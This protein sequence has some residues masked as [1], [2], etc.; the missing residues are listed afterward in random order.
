MKKLNIM[1]I[2]GAMLCAYISAQAQNLPLL[3]VRA[4]ILAFDG[5]EMQVRTREGSNLKIRLSDQTK[6]NVLK[7]IH[8]ADIKQGSFVGITAISHGPGTPLQAREVHLFPEAQRGT[9]EGHY[10][11]DLEPG[12]SMTNANVD[13]IVDTNNGKEMT[14]SYKGGNQKIVVSRD[15]PIVAFAPADAS[16]LKPGTYVFCITQQQADG[17][18]VAQRISVGLNG[19][20]PP[21]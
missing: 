18:L 2:V 12:S 10:D 15:I 13:A 16:V 11:W 4:A 20:K 17:S 6:V 7:T 14:L 1:F 5:M 19:M 9:G 8:L 3:R 21:M